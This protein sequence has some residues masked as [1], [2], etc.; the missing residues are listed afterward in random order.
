[1][2]QPTLR[3]MLFLIVSQKGQ[4]GTHASPLQCCA[5]GSS[6]LCSWIRCAVLLGPPLIETPGAS[7]KGTAAPL[8]GNQACEQSVFPSY[9]SPSLL[10]PWVLCAVYAVQAKEAEPSVL[11]LGV[12]TTGQLTVWYPA[13]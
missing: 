13:L 9:S 6:V 7:S 2:G 12:D 8:Q 1:M 4:Y 11:R 10:C 3:T 5:P